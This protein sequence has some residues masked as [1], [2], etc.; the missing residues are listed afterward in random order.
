MSTSVVPHTLNRL[1]CNQPSLTPSHARPSEARQLGAPPSPGPSSRVAALSAVQS[2]AFCGK[3][4]A[5]F[6]ACCADRTN[7]QPHPHLSHHPGVVRVMGQAALITDMMRRLTR[8]GCGPDV[9]CLQR[10]DQDIP[11]SRPEFK[12]QIRQAPHGSPRF[13]LEAD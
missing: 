4:A 3:R 13:D 6:R 7:H 12:H 8:W 2:S 5:A 1:N 9:L 10:D 11:P